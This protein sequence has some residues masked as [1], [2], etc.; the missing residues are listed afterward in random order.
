MI[1]KK[2]NFLMIHSFSARPNFS[3]VKLF[4]KQKSGSHDGMCHYAQDDATSN[5]F[6][7]TNNKEQTEKEN[8]PARNIRDN[9]MNILNSNNE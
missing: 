1:Y 5:N 9:T 3:L 6:S 7:S 4:I 2:I 8:T